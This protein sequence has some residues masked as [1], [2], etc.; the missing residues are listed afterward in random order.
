MGKIEYNGVV[1]TVK[2]VDGMTI[3]TGIEHNP[4]P[5]SIAIPNVVNEI[6]PLFDWSQLEDVEVLS[7]S[8]RTEDWIDLD[9]NLPNLSDI[10]LSEDESGTHMHLYLSYSRPGKLRKLN[11][12]V[13]PSTLLSIGGTHGGVHDIY[14]NEV[15]FNGHLPLMDEDVF[16]DCCAKKII[17]NAPISE[18]DHIPSA[19]L[20]L[21]YL[22][23]DERKELE[24]MNKDELKLKLRDDGVIVFGRPPLCNEES[25]LPGY[26]KVTAYQVDKRLV[27]DEIV[28]INAT[29]I[30]MMETV[31]KP[32]EGTRIHLVNRADGF[33][34]AVV[35]ESRE[36]VEDKIK[37]AIGIIDANTIL[38]HLTT[39]VKQNKYS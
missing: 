16:E 11:R 36:Q 10:I 4:D 19:L 25:T 38:S 28:E 7:L 3:L 31:R 1:F 12:I 17:I 34:E 21:M 35:Y 14:F 6:S 33:H 37:D 18:V 8:P 30:T 32:I 23:S 13:L 2:E 24:I 29:F 27:S 5:T 22:S 26:I 39:L 9:G 15:V 20:N